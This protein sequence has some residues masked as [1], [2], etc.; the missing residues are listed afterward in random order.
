MGALKSLKRR[1]QFNPDLWQKMSF[2]RTTD[3]VRVAR[4]RTEPAVAPDGGPELRV[5]ELAPSAASPDVR[6]DIGAEEEDSGKL[7]REGALFLG[8]AKDPLSLS[9]LKEHVW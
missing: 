9:G 5:I 4:V 3:G 7:P 6:K 1:I 2:L 8:L